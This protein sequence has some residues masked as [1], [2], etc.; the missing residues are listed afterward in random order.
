MSETSPEEGLLEK[1]V[2]VVEEREEKVLVVLASDKQKDIGQTPSSH[3]TIC[4]V[5]LTGLG[6]GRLLEK[7]KICLLVNSNFVSKK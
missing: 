2:H 5:Q 3:V 6:V 7:S 1:E 4:T